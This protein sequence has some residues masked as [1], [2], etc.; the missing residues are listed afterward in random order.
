[1]AHWCSFCPTP[2]V[3]C[4]LRED[5]LLCQK[6]SQSHHN[7]SPVISLEERTK[8]CDAEAAFVIA[9]SKDNVENTSKYY[10]A[11]WLKF[12]D[13]LK[14]FRD[15]KF[16]IS[17]DEWKKH[18]EKHSSKVN[19]YFQQ[20]MG[21][22]KETCETLR[23]A[24]EMGRQNTLQRLDEISKSQN[25][26]IE[27]QIETVQ[28]L[29]GEYRESIF[30]LEDSIEQSNIER[31]VNSRRQLQKAKKEFKDL[32]MSLMTYPAYE[33]LW[34]VPIQWKIPSLGSVEEVSLVTT[35]IEGDGL[36][37]QK[38]G[39]GEFTIT[40]KNKYAGPRFFL[41]E[42]LEFSFVDEKDNDFTSDIELKLT[43]NQDRS[44]TVVYNSPV[45][46]YEKLSQRSFQLSILFNG[47]HVRGSPFKV[48][49][50]TDDPDLDEEDAG[51]DPGISLFD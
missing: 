39:R 49:T 45:D 25:E 47:R 9:K 15:S 4:C 43:R 18:V 13:S 32:K 48:R 42:D 26:L 7:H 38:N 24:I 31:R 1:M 51:E 44:M 40:A 16:V 17:D 28:R 11:K 20:T 29:L 50:R 30:E 21:D 8:I 27:W 5:V 2:A 36:I 34:I 19:K 10:S 46:L 22:F 6:H 14:E 12:H 41:E 35:L 3:V 23:T 37:A 33:A